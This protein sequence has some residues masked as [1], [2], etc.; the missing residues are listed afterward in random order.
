MNQGSKQ[1]QAR[2]AGA[3][4]AGRQDGF[5]LVELIVTVSIAAILMV[6]A[7]PSFRWL[8]NTNRIT[9]P[10]NEL[11]ASLQIARQEAI[12][13]NT[14]V[15][16]CRSDNPD[17]GAA[18]ACSAAAGA[19]PGWIVFVDNGDDGTGTIVAGNARNSQRNAGE[20]L[21]RTGT[22]LAPLQMRA[23]TNLSGQNNRVVFRSEGLARPVANGPTLAAT[24]SVCIP[25]SQPAQN[26]REV[27]LRA[28]SRVSVTRNTNIAC[29]APGN[30]PL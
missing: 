4:R 26:V 14:R 11:A 7:V 21:I 6:I 10:A 19:W 12:R 29:T 20:T 24:I 5:S 13:R 9:A 22:V 3:G 18:A 23:S 1:L 27:R 17:A 30:P 2:R 16:L 8:L 15:V 28:G 25:T